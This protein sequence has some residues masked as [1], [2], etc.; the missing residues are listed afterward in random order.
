ML[1]LTQP[2]YVMPIHGDYKRLRLH[3]ELAEAVGVDPDGI[4]QG[5]NGLPLEIDERG[6][7]FGERE[8]AG[9]VFVDGVEI[10]DV[11]DVALRDRRMLS[12]D[13]IFIVVVTVAERDLRSVADP[14]VIFRGVPF[15]D[16]A[17]ELVAEIRATVAG[18]LLRAA[19]EEIDEVDLLQRILHDD[20][21]TL[22]YDR[23]HRRPMVLPVVV[24]V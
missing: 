1:N 24:E 9:M 20:L 11:T 6:A 2:R 10:G 5:E 7:R 21:A 17:G 15:L 12:A 13:G 22:V 4:F 18:S 3:A 14:E 8:R 19:E 16:D 23:L